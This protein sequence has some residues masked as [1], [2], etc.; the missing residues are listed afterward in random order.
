MKKLTKFHKETGCNQ[1][2]D[3][4]ASSRTTA[5][6]KFETSNDRSK[7][8]Q[9]LDSSAKKSLHN[10]VFLF[11][12]THETAGKHNANNLKINKEFP[13]SFSLFVLS[14]YTYHILVKSN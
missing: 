4:V 13:F 9:G 14:F 5:K 8:Q 1:N 3:Q 12:G 7:L 11:N 10:F 2:S 6:L